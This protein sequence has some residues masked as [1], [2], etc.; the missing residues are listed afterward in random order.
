[1]RVVTST[2]LTS[3]IISYGCDRFLMNEI[4]KFRSD[5]W[6]YVQNAKDISNNINSSSLP[7]VYKDVEFLIK[8]Y[9]HLQQTSYSTLNGM[10]DA[11][12][13]YSK[14]CLSGQTRIMNNNHFNIFHKVANNHFT[15]MEKIQQFNVLLEKEGYAINQNNINKNKLRWKSLNDLFGDIKEGELNTIN[16]HSNSNLIFKNGKVVDLNSSNLDG[17][18]HYISTL[19]GHLNIVF[20][21]EQS[22]IYKFF[23]L[24]S[25]KGPFGDRIL[26][27]KGNDNV[28]D[29]YATSKCVYLIG[30]NQTAIV[31]Q[32]FNNKT[33]LIPQS[34]S[35]K[36]SVSI[37][38]SDEYLTF[39]NKYPTFKFDDKIRDLKSNLSNVSAVH[40]ICMGSVDGCSVVEEGVNA[41]Q[42]VADI[43]LN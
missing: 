22:G 1:M 4:N 40:D 15:L 12:S 21:N 35:N 14:N 3:R 7:E 24:S 37:P 32:Q 11:I 8:S 17:C 38:S 34:L 28:F 27:I 9:S 18:D 29:S 23:T 33:M 26:L 16:Y 13:L 2:K 10:Y 42:Q 36:T 6:D 20:Y 41:V 31:P 19:K 39:L 5:Q 30:S 43:L 25:K